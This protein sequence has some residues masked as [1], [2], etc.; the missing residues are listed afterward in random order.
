MMLICCLC[1]AFVGFF[2]S[3]FLYKII[4]RYFLNQVHAIQMGTH[5]ICLY[6]EVDKKYTG[7]NLKSMELIDCA[8]TGVYVVNRWSMII[9]SYDLHVNGYNHHEEKALWRTVTVNVLKF[10]TPKFLTKCHMQTV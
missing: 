9:C 7:C 3:D 6:K 1:D 5:N 4:C 2:F 10:R 8:L